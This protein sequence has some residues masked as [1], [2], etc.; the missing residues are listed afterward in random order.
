MTS[1][2]RR[3]GVVRLTE[4]ADIV[5]AVPH[6][7]GFHPTESLVAV[8]MTGRRE[9][10]SFSMRVDLPDDGD[11]EQVVDV[12]VRAMSRARAEAVLLFVYTDAAPADGSL[13][14]DAFVEQLFDA[15]P[16]PVRDALLVGAGR[17]WSYVCTDSVCCPPEGRPLVRETPGSLALAAAHALVGQSV[18]PSRDALV[19]SLRP[20]DDEDGELA[21][22]T[23]RAAEVFLAAGEDGFRAGALAVLDDLLQR[24]ADPPAAMTVDEAALVVVALH[25]NAFRDRV[26]QR[27]L[28]RSDEMRSLLGDLV[29]HAL[30]PLD[31]PVCTALATV[32]YLQ[33]DGAVAGAALDRAFASEPDYL[34]A[35]LLDTALRDQVSPADVRRGLSGFTPA[36]RRRSGRRS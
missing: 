2:A 5:N 7:L 22:A 31:A 35:C 34:L 9:R 28:D 18:L 6:L 12:C 10:L 15:L 25:D 11:E 27:C 23:D 16:M 3:A 21:D 30:P 36:P 33:G 8:A 29:R 17:V 19:T 32:A 4:L 26:V 1:P 20:L 14:R 24:Y 13:P